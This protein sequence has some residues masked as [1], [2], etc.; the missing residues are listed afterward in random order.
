MENCCSRPEVITGLDG[1]TASWNSTWLGAESRADSGSQYFEVQ[2]YIS[3][4]GR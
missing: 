4:V 1:H 2:D 3:H